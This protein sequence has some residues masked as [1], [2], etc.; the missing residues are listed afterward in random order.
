M[1][2]SAPSYQIVGVVADLPEHRDVRV[3]YQPLAAD[4]SE[5]ARLSL[6]VGT[7][8]A[9]LAARLWEIAQ[10]LDPS[11]RLT[12]VHTLDDVYRQSQRDDNL[13]A[14]ALAAATLCVLLL[15]A[16]GIY[17][18]MSFT[19]TRRHREIGIRSALGARP[20]RVLLEISKG[21]LLQVGA[22]AACGTLIAS[23]LAY[24]VPV[25]ELG[26]RAIPG[27]VPAAAALMMLVGLLAAIGPARRGLAVEPIEALREG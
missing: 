15:S 26:G 25:E 16:A 8:A 27:L 10:G 5:A 20:H 23:G 18:L 22:G 24:W 9:T 4:D 17:A 19:I 7:G 13:P 6:R 2:E 1:P 12:D 14:Y 21:A 3:V 11:L